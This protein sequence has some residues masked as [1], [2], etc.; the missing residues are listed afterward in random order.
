MEV[1][2]PGGTRVATLALIE[3]Q[4]SHF[5]LL[6]ALG[7]GESGVVGGIARLSNGDEELPA[8]WLAVNLSDQ[9]IKKIILVLGRR[10]GVCCLEWL[11]WLQEPA[12]RAGIAGRIDEAKRIQTVERA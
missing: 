1:N 8:Q 7:P 11:H 6:P 9:R 10:S 4:G 3:R 2:L 5:L 12:Y